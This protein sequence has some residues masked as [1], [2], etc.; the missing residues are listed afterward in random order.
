MRTNALS[1]CVG[2]TLVCLFIISAFRVNDEVTTQY[3]SDH[4]TQAFRHSSLPDN[5]HPLGQEPWKAGADSV[6]RHLTAHRI[7]TL[8]QTENNLFSPFER[9]TLKSFKQSKLPSK[10]FSSRVSLDQGPRPAAAINVADT[11]KRTPQVRHR[12]GRIVRDCPISQQF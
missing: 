11:H 10:F 6:N 3:F 8:E 2:H 9:T 1:C 7:L 5:Q 12:Q 4:F